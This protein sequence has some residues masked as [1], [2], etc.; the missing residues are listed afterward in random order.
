[1]V[2]SVRLFGF[3]RNRRR[4]TLALAIMGVMTLSRHAL[5]AQG[6]PPYDFT[7]IVDGNTARPDG[8]GNFSP[9]LQ[10][11][12]YGIDGDWVAFINQAAG[13]GPPFEIWS[14]NLTTQQYTKLVDSSTAVPG[15]AAGSSFSDFALCGYNGYQLELHDGYVVFLGAI[16][17]APTCNFGPEGGLYSVPAA[18]GAVSRIVDYTMALPGSG[19]NFH[20]AGGSYNSGISVSQGQVVFQASS[21]NGDEGVWAASVNGSGLERIADE[22]TAYNCGSCHGGNPNLYSSPFILAGNVVF[23]GSGTFGEE[24]WSTL[25]VTPFTS[26]GLNPVLNSSQP[27]P[28]DTGPE[29]PNNG[30]YVAAWS[31]VID[32]NHIYFVATDPNF[33]GSCASAFTGV[34][35]TTLAGGTATKIADTCDN[36]ASVGVLNAPNSFEYLAAGGGTVVFQVENSSGSTRAIYASANG[37]LGPV[38]AEGD[39]MLGTTVYSLPDTNGNNSVSDGRIL[40]YAQL[41][42]SNSGNG[43]YLATTRLPHLALPALP[44]RRR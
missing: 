1:M 21:S 5:F 36:L 26:P 29:S 11:A 16:S 8:Q 38:I 28:D 34:F 40:F 43:L 14:Y 39:P 33:A 9:F 3:R 19:G 23:A 2:F 13:G 4:G 30:I 35:V 18:G 41:N 20:G 24:G 10:W 17:T 32:G 15:A 27:L 22:N 6:L 37:V 31:P 42:S 25:F 12:S 44:A 7:K